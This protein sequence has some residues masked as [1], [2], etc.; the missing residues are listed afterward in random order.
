MFGLFK[1]KE[2]SIQIN[3]KILVSETEKWKALQTYC[4]NH[5]NTVLI[6]WFE[7]T[8][9]QAA[10]VLSPEIPLLLSREVYAHSIA[11]KTPVFAEHHPMLSKEKALFEK[12]GLTAI[13]IYSA[14][15]EPL[16][17][18]FGSDKIISMMKQL[19]MKEDEIIEHNM[20]T[21]AIRN[22]QEKIEKKLIV[23]HHASSQREWMEKNLPA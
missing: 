4:T 1:K 20:I 9:D 2:G 17:K 13:T 23:D 14:L 21:K 19:G 16:F 5:P 11:G 3:E 10:T 7:E 15:A 22:A 8:L 12:L 6:F 18:H